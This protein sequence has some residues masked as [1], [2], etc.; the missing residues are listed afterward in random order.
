MEKKNV[1][2]T[3]SGIF[4]SI[5]KDIDEF[6]NN[7]RDGKTGAGSI[8][9]FETGGLNTRCAYE[10]GGFEPK[11]YLGKKGLRYLDRS[12]LLLLCLLKQIEM[13]IENLKKECRLGLVVGTAF[14]NVESI[15]DFY[16]KGKND[17]PDYVSPMAFPNTVINAAASQANIRYDI[18]HSS[19]TI[20]NGFT[21]S[22][23]AIK[24]GCNNILLD[25]SD[26]VIVCGV[27]VLSQ[28][29]FKG[30]YANKLLTPEDTI[31]PFSSTSRGTLLGEG[32]GFIILESQEYARQR[33]A[34]SLAKIEG[35]ST[36]YKT[37]Q[38]RFSDENPEGLIYT[39][40]R[41][42]E[43]SES[44]ADSISAVFAGANG[45]KAADA[46][47]AAA[48]KKVFSSHKDVPVTALKS[49]IGECYGASGLLQTVGAVQSLQT[50]SL[51]P[52]A[53]S[54]DL[55]SGLNVVTKHE[56]IAID[57][58]LVNSYGCGNYSSLI[59]SANM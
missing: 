6:W 29:E 26:V 53:A 3:G 36:Y 50:D 4:S 31:R 19:V 33:G 54:D 30:F 28:P 16:Y 56:S 34:K 47:E 35:I 14:G 32:A 22:L 24:Y 21:S 49:S 11:D 43:Q 39:M 57:R 27:D 7:C 8:S 37:T 48:V 55:I 52:T 20:S 25:Y 41:A 58:V 2:I 1:V 38:A 40:N 13:Q 9:L 45:I 17:G 12:T 59:L 5:G 46:M 42:L 44:G 15:Y 10:I 23:D 18:S 51:I